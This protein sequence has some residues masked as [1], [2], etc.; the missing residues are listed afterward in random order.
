[1]ET[2]GISIFL[3]RL[4]PFKTNAAANAGLLTISPYE[5]RFRTWDFFQAEPRTWA[6]SQDP[7]RSIRK[8]GNQLP[9]QFIFQHIRR[10][11]DWTSFFFSISCRLT[12]LSKAQVIFLAQ[13]FANESLVQEHSSPFHTTSAQIMIVP[14]F[15]FLSTTSLL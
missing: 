1:M 12:N 10:S 8:N 11:M 5:A 9:I 13:I 3:R 7:V 15:S 2:S 14:L 4:M 6:T